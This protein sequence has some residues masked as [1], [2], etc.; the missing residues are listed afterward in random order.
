[1]DGYCIPKGIS[2]LS[3]YDHMQLSPHFIKD[4]DKLD[5]KRFMG[6]KGTL[7]SNTKGRIDNRDLFTFGWGK[8]SCPGVHLVRKRIQFDDK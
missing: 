1:V 3:S 2:I 5:F 4:G 7:L 6:T 8:R